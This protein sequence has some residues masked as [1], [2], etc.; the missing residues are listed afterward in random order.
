V[1]GEEDIKE[2]GQVMDRLSANNIEQI[3]RD[4]N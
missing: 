3:R 1:I 4:E 2:D